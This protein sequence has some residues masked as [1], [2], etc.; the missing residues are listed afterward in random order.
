MRGVAAELVAGTDLCLRITGHCIPAA[1]GTEESP[2]G[3]ARLR[4]RQ[5]YGDWVIFRSHVLVT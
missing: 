3:F 2:D 5:V 4:Q 1:L